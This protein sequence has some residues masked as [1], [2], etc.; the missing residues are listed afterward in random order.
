MVFSPCY[1]YEC[2]A[3]T[4]F[5]TISSILNKSGGLAGFITIGF[6]YSSFTKKNTK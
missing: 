3:L 2:H 1:E 5:T 4:G 6:I